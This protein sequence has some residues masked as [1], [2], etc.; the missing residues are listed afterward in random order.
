MFAN[1]ESTVMKINSI[2][3]ITHLELGNCILLYRVNGNVLALSRYR[4]KKEVHDASN[5]LSNAS[6]IIYLWTLI[7]LFFSN[8]M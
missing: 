6:K 2:F 3:Y 1:L 4:P 5:L 8:S 7:V